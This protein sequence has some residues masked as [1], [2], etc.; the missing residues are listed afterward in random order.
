MEIT[1][2]DPSVLTYYAAFEMFGDETMVIPVGTSFIDPGV[3]A[4]IKDQRCFRIE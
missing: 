3:K 4:T 2:E 1:S